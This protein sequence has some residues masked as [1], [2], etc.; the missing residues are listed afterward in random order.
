MSLFGSQLQLL[1]RDFVLFCTKMVCWCTWCK[2]QKQNFSEQIKNMPPKEAHTILIFIYVRIFII[3]WMYIDWKRCKL[4]QVSRTEINLTQP[5]AMWFSFGKTLPFSRVLRG[6]WLWFPIPHRLLPLA[7]GHVVV[8]HISLQA[9]H[10][11]S[12]RLDLEKNVEQKSEHFL[13]KKIEHF[14]TYHKSHVFVFD[15]STHQ[16]EVMFSIFKC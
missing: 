12:Q 15:M 2:K 8:I 3:F 11:F 5:S 10:H 4:M 1:Q 7:H 6:S 13:S 14:R 16:K 9:D